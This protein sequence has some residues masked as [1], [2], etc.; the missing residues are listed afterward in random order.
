MLRDYD[1]TMF[2]DTID[3]ITSEMSSESFIITMF[4]NNSSTNIEITCVIY[5][6]NTSKSVHLLYYLDTVYRML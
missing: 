6:L 5:T 1:A 4:N 2:N 3:F